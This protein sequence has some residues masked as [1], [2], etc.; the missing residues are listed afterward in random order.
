MVVS[1]PVS[2]A[3]RLVFEYEGREVWLRSSESVD[4]PVPATDLLDDQL[5]VWVEVRDVDGRALHRRV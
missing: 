3:V 1:E 2:R 5:G 4:A